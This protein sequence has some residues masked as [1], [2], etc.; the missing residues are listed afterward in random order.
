[1]SV[2]TTPEVSLNA[3]ETRQLIA[4]L[5]EI[6]Q[7]QQQLLTLLQEEKSLIIEGKTE[8]LIRC[9]GKKESILKRVSELETARMRLIEQITP[10]HPPLTLK[11]LMPRILPVY[12]VPLEKLRTRLD[13]LTASIA[14]L[15]E[16]NGVL[17]ERVLGQISDLFTLLRHMTAGGETYEPSG[18]MRLA[19]SGRTISR[20]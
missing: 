20:G 16:M 7:F 8:E 10:G 3:P 1:M 14:E 19:P 5:E 13:V 9:I 18:E 2:L 12:R 6:L 4:I 11:S 15:N 17:I